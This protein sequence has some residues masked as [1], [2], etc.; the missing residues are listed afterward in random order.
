MSDKKKINVVSFIDER[1]VGRYQ[2]FIIILVFLVVAFDGMDVAI[3]GFAA[4]EIIRTWGITK[5]QMGSILG[6][7]FFGVAVGALIAGPIGDRYGRKLILTASV[8]WFGVLTLV[9]SQAP[10]VNT[11]ITLRI[12]TGL[13]LGA[14]L[15]NAVT[16]ISEYV[17]V[18]KRSLIVTI[19]YSGF[20]GG[21]A[22]AGLIA[23]WLLQVFGWR[24]MIAIGG[25][26]PIVLALILAIWLP[27]SVAFL[28]LKGKRL[29]AI[30]KIL[31]KIDRGSSVLSDATFWI[32]TPVDQSKGSVAILFTKAYAMGTFLLCVAYFMGVCAT[33]V[34]VNWLPVI[35]KDAG[36]TL[37]QGVVITTLITLGGPIGSICI[38]AIMDRVRPHWVLV[39]TF[40]IAG[41]FLASLSVAPRNFGALCVL[42]FALGCFFHGSMTGLQALSAMSFPT[43]ARSTGISWMHGFGRLGAIASGFIGATMMGWGWG[44]GQIFLALAVPMVVAACAVAVLGMRNERTRIEHSEIGSS[45]ALSLRT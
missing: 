6:A 10:D 2:I 37:G 23:A 40:L 1:P 24:V 8:F 5:S 3:M 26:L 31:R 17:P 43:A 9:S 38:G 7:V 25:L 11:L 27:E 22:V 30:P 35:A 29:A 4:P 34:M 39:P 41:A 20:T 14:A 36:F 33:Y 21:A 28:T 18:R 45:Q 12:L 15:P 13:G 19:V 42:M 44:L 16:L 32:P